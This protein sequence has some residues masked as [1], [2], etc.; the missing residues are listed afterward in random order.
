[1]KPTLDSLKKCV[2][3]A[4]ELGCLMRWIASFERELPF[5]LSILAEALYD[6]VGDETFSV[7]WFKELLQRWADKEFLGE[8]VGDTKP[9]KEVKP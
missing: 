1:M 7:T 5:K 8:E 9:Q 4:N 3:T 2:D 6:Y